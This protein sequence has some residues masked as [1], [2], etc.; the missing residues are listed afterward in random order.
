MQDNTMCNK[1]EKG[2]N[3]YQIS[4]A[5]GNSVLVQNWA[6][7]SKL[8]GLLHGNGYFLCFPKCN[9]KVIL[10]LQYYYVTVRSNIHWF[11]FVLCFSLKYKLCY[12]CRDLRLCTN[13]LLSFLQR[14]SKWVRVASDS[15][16]C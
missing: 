10:S 15:A 7:R 4:K 6:G 1:E 11:C 3:K 14:P 2:H 9:I 12:T 8:Q 5:C 13:L 16:S